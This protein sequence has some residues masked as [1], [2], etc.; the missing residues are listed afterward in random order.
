MIAGESN[1]ASAHRIQLDVATANEEVA[2]SLDKTGF[3]SPLPQRSASAIGSV[4]VLGVELSDAFH[5]ARAPA[6]VLRREKQVHVICHQAVGMQRAAC[7]R[8]H[9]REM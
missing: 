1:H 9:A 2:F 4:H 5:E 8:Q 6:D 3:E 7:S